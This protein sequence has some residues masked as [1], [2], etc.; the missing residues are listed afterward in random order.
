MDFQLPE[1]QEVQKIHRDE[2]CEFKNNLSGSNI[3][4]EE[5]IERLRGSYY[6]K[7]HSHNYLPLIAT[8]KTRKKVRLP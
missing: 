1:K 3:I 6:S 5:C 8:Q 4:F 2:F 7:F